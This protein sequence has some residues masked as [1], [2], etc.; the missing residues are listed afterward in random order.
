MEFAGTVL[1]KNA[2]RQW[3]L[4]NR[5]GKTSNFRQI[6]KNDSAVYLEGINNRQKMRIDFFTND[7]TILARNGEQASYEMTRSLR[8]NENFRADQRIKTNNAVVA[9]PGVP[10][11]RGSCFDYTAYTNGGD[12]GL[13]FRGHEDL[14]FIRLGKKP[15]KGR[16]CHSGQLVFE[17]SKRNQ[18]TD[19]VLEIQGQKFRFAAN[20]EYS[21][22]H[23]SWYRNWM[24]VNVVR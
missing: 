8:P 2:E 9:Q 23:N 22:F 21:E 11:V 3:S 6:S 16:L 4:T 7:V 12:G 15:H 13:R 18:A 19:V 14:E 24:E 1:E 10:I 5:N 20:A 17:I